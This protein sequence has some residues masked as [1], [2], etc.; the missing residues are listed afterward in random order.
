M[1]PSNLGTDTFGK[2]KK[3]DFLITCPAAANH[4]FIEKIE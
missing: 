4:F 3:L 1:G 2:K